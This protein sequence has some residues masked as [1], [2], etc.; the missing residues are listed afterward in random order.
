MSGVNGYSRFKN[1]STGIITID[2]FNLYKVNLSIALEVVKKHFQEPL[3]KYDE[4]LVFQKFIEVILLNSRPVKDN[5]GTE[6]IINLNTVRST[7]IP[8][9]TPNKTDKKGRKV[10]WFE[11]YK[12]SWINACSRYIFSNKKIRKSLGLANEDVY[13]I[14]TGSGIEGKNRKIISTEPDFITF[15]KDSNSQVED[16][17]QGKYIGMYHPRYPVD[18][19]RD[20]TKTSGWKIEN[21]KSCGKNVFLL[22]AKDVIKFGIS[23]EGRHLVVIGYWGDH[24]GIDRIVE[25]TEA[26]REILQNFNSE[27]VKLII[28]RPFNGNFN[29]VKIID[30]IQDSWRM[31]KGYNLTGMPSKDTIP[32]WKKL[33]TITQNSKNITEFYLRILDYLASTAEKED[34]NIKNQDVKH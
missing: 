31:P 18:F 13:T 32:T 16:I 19:F 28:E 30:Q 6:I 29:E 10:A 5:N 1:Y 26:A 27:G 2:E 34:L 25:G 17:I 7:G 21:K 3:Y 9:S 24:R 4:H 12:K 11:P 33:K 15:S 22:K 14:S 8:V 23:N 20:L